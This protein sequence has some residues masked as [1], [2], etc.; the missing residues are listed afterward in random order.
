MSVDRATFQ[1]QPYNGGFSEQL[2]WTFV[3]FVV[4]VAAI[5]A[6]AVVFDT[7]IILRRKQ[8]QLDLK[9]KKRRGP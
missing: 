5:A 9:R 3:V 4:A 6:G 7:W 8:R 2:F 1:L